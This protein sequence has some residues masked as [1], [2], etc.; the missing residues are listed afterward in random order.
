MKAIALGGPFG[1]VSAVLEETQVDGDEGIETFF[2]EGEGIAEAIAGV[3]AIRKGGI[4]NGNALVTGSCGEYDAGW[5]DGLVEGEAPSEAIDPSFM[6]MDEIDF[7]IAFEK[8]GIRAI[9]Y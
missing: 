8:F 4:A 6:I 9:G 3:E 7:A 5:G 1:T 2:A